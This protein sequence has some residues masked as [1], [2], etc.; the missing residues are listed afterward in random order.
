MFFYLHGCNTGLDIIYS[1]QQNNIWPE[2]MEGKAENKTSLR[3]VEK[4]L[5]NWGCTALFGLGFPL[6]KK[7][8]AIWTQF[9]QNRT[10]RYYS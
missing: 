5:K 7:T 1:D 9:Q 2:H 6:E 3:E 4:Y 8:R 10:L